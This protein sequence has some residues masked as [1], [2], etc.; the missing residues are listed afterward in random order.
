MSEVRVA[1]EDIIDD[2]FNIF[3]RHGVRSYQ[4]GGVS[5]A[6][7]MLQ[8]AWAAE[9]AAAAPHLV[10]AALLHDVGHFSTDFVRLKTDP[11]HGAMLNA[12][13]DGGH[14]E[15][16]AQLLNPFFRA[17][18]VEPIRLHVKA[19][20]YLCAV[21]HDYLKILSPQ[22]VHTLHL[23]GGPM[24][25]EETVVFEANPHGQA[26]AMVR[27]WDDAALVPGLRTPNFEYYRPLLESLLRT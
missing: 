21:E 15:A 16:G 20:R 10:A 11:E 9:G 7:H 2:L 8:A 27:R 12:T 24:S 3:A 13:I 18:V 23:Q 1:Q 6:E 4:G 5:M 17:D 25:P 26:A 22:A 14:E 19:K